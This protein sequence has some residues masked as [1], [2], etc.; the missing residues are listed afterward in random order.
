MPGGEAWGQITKPELVPDNLYQRKPYYDV[1][2]V[3]MNPPGEDYYYVG[4]GFLVS[5]HVMVTAA[6]VV[7]DPE[8][9]SWTSKVEFRQRAGISGSPTYNVSYR[10]YWTEYASKTSEYPTPESFNLDFATGYRVSGFSYNGSEYPSYVYEK[11]PVGTNYVPSTFNEYLYQFAQFMIVGYPT[12]SDYISYWDRGRMHLTE[13]GYWAFG[14]LSG[15]ESYNGWHNAVYFSDE[16]TA[17]GGNSGSPLYIN[18]GSEVEPDWYPCGVTVGGIDNVRT[19]FRMIDQAAHTLIQESIASSGETGPE[20]AL[21][22][23]SQTHIRLQWDDRPGVVTYHLYRSENADMSGEVY[24]GSTD[25][26]IFVDEPEG[27]GPTYYYRITGTTHFEGAPMEFPHA[28]RA[29]LSQDERLLWRMPVPAI[30]DNGS[31]GSLALIEDRLYYSKNYY[32]LTGDTRFPKHL[33]QYPG[34]DSYYKEVY[35]SITSTDGSSIFFNQSGAVYQ[36]DDWFESTPMRNVNNTSAII[37]PA[38]N[39]LIAFGNHYR[40]SYRYTMGDLVA[41]KLDNP[42]TESD[43]GLGQRDL[44]RSGY[45]SGLGSRSG[46]LEGLVHNGKSAAAYVRINSDDSATVVS[47]VPNVSQYSILIPANEKSVYIINPDFGIHCLD[48]ATGSELWQVESPVYRPRTYSN[49]L[50]QAAVTFEGDLLYYDESDSL[51]RLD[52]DTGNE[53]WRARV[54]SDEACGL[55]LDS[56]GRIYTMTR[57]DLLCIDSNDGSILWRRDGLG[58][59][60][61]SELVNLLLVPGGSLYILKE[62]ELLAFQ[63]DS[64]GP[65]YSAWPQYQADWQNT[66]REQSIWGAAH[67]IGANVRYYDWFGAFEEVNGSWLD[68][69]KLGLMYYLDNGVESIWLWSV[70]YERWFWL[71]KGNGPF[72]YDFEDGNWIFYSERT[73]QLFEFKDNAWYRYRG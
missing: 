31:V 24:I 6:H 22:E 63:T 40:A 1:G 53:M 12:D 73:N 26:N 13:P 61:E 30:H 67:R 9:L 69:K 4:S 15:D 11:A 68:H 39:T 10:N 46:L 56:D 32:Q 49:E 70:K 55:A 17:Y 20:F 52:G 33:G 59:I 51:R 28:I 41:Q 29:T 66:N 44:F 71:T 5:K 64:D 47:K 38:P 48:R 65:A 27:G 37:S 45:I 57:E 58:T 36:L 18:L 16:V 25:E 8:N 14:H 23:A 7:Y 62:D 34:I 42:F 60:D 54:S 3:L 21:Q 35:S 2:R 43:L 19:V 50:L 72:L